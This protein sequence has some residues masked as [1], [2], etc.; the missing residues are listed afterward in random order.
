MFKTIKLFGI[1]SLS[2]SLLLLSC[3]SDSAESKNEKTASPKSAY[4][5][6][7]EGTTVFE[8]T[9]YKFADKSGPVPGGFNEI[10]VESEGAENAKDVIESIRFK[11]ATASV[12][13]QNEDRNKKIAEFFFG[14]INTPE[15][16]GK[17][18]ELKDNG[19]ALVTIRMNGI[20]FDIEGDYELD[21]NDFSFNA[22]IDVSNWNGM[23]GINKLNEV[24][25][26]L[27]KKTPKDESKLWSEVTLKLTTSLKKVI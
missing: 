15:I 13:T 17:F 24:C 14:T 22:S 27:H 10:E 6:Y 21:D 4:Y 25:E 12:E 9:A 8:W 2:T 7:N 1:L 11:I 26:D 16:T 3:K 20:D 18:V 5:E 23:P 19:K